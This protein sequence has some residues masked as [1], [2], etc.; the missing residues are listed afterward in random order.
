M[1]CLELIIPPS[2]ISCSGAA[3]QPDSSSTNHYDSTPHL[4]SRYSP[5]SSLPSSG[6]HRSR[7]LS[8]HTDSLLDSSGISFGNGY[9]VPLGVCMESPRTRSRTEHALL[10]ASGID[11]PCE[12]S[13]SRA[14]DTLGSRFC[15]IRAGSDRA[16]LPGSLCILHS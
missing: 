3:H 5:I 4:R 9:P 13:S 11:H 2:G 12:Y 6:S 16:S 8:R 10:Q 7:S 1:V 14:E 15:E